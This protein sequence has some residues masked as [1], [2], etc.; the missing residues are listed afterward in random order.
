MALSVLNGSFVTTFGDLNASSLFVKWE[1]AAQNPPYR[2]AQ[3][4]ART[5]ARQ[6]LRLRQRLGAENGDKSWNRSQFLA[7]ALGIICSLATRA[8]C[9]T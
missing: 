9:D 6:Q 2:S 5:H 8:I 3:R 4:A 1:I 7:V